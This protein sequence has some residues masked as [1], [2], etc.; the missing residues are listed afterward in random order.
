MNCLP[1]DKDTGTGFYLTSHVAQ[2]RP[3]SPLQ[4][5]L[6]TLA[7]VS[8]SVR[9]TAKE[10]ALNKKHVFHYPKIDGSLFE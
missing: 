6:Q 4:L 10:K 5:L 7:Y 1:A 2:N 9:V 3:A 8:G